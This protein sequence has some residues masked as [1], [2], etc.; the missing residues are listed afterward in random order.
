VKWLWVCSGDPDMGRGVFSVVKCTKNPLLAT[1]TLLNLKR[2]DPKSDHWIRK[3]VEH[4]DRDYKQ[5]KCP[6]CGNEMSQR[7]LD[8][9]WDWAGPH[10]NACGCTGMSMFS[11]V[12]LNPIM[13]GYQGVKSKFASVLGWDT[14]D[15][16]DRKERVKKEGC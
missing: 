8:N 12:T 9:T 11:A 13:S 5:F 4:H 6:D 10:C 3:D 2:K 14:I 16:I 1:A 15:E 7:E